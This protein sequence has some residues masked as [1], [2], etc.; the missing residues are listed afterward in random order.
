MRFMGEMKELVDSIS[1]Y[2]HMDVAI[3]KAWSLS[4]KGDTL[5]FSPACPGFDQVEDYRQRGE[6][7]NKIVSQLK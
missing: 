7:F 2:D 5:L 4:R 3:Y 6:I 1:W